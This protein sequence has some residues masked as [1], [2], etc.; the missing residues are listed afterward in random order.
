M[1]YKFPAE[2]TD[3][4]DC[5]LRVNAYRDSIHQDPIKMSSLLTYIKTYNKL[6]KDIG[7]NDNED[8]FMNDP[9]RVISFIKNMPGRG[10]VGISTNTQRNYFSAVIQLGQVCL[11]PRPLM[12]TYML[13]REKLNKNY[14]K[15]LAKSEFDEKEKEQVPIL[16]Q[17]NI[18]EILRDIPNKDEEVRIFLN[19]DGLDYRISEFD[20]YDKLVYWVTMWIYHFNRLRNDLCYCDMLTQV[21]LEVHPKRDIGSFLVQQYNGDWHILLGDWKTKRQD[22][23]SKRLNMKG[24]SM[25]TNLLTKW[26]NANGREGPFIKNPRTNTKMSSKMF[27]DFMLKMN[28][29]YLGHRIGTRM[30]RKIFYSEKYGDFIKTI[31]ADAEQNLHSVGTAMNI[32]TK[33]IPSPNV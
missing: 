26:F 23:D 12:K 7:Y 6:S 17:F 27:T 13:E 8:Y 2:I 9:K 20:V 25:I 28:D 21:E 33:E 22:D 30:L 29:K 32:Y 5:F 11:L 15:K 18:R 14:E 3:I 16:T 19:Y 1:D 10:G 31:K 24:G 4:E